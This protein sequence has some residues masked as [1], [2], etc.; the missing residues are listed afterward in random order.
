M[1]IIAYILLVI[2]GDICIA[3]VNTLPPWYCELQSSL[4]NTTVAVLVVIVDAIFL[5]KYIL[6]FYLKN[7][8]IAHD[9]FWNLFLRIWIIS[10]V[11]FGQCVQFFFSERKTIN[12][13]VCIRD[14]PTSDHNLQLKT[15]WF[16]VALFMFSIIL[17]SLIYVKVKLFVKKG[18]TLQSKS[19]PK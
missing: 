7:P 11:F 9:D 2:P 1:V 18:K 14:F 12:Y 19:H 10:F 5:V 3:L 6:I 8:S 16:N 17:C 15:G 13:Y 4:K